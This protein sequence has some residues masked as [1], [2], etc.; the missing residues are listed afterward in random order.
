MSMDDTDNAFLWGFIRR[1][2][3]TETIIQLDQLNH[4]R[5]E[6]SN[7]VWVHLRSDLSRSRKSMQALGL[8]DQVIDVMCADET[9]PKAYAFADGLV[10]YLRGINHNQH[11]DP[12]DMVSLRV[13]L[14]DKLVVTARKRDRGLK[15]AMT[16]KE[17]CQAGEG[18][19][20]AQGLFCS[21]L[22]EM[23]NTVGD[24]VDE[25]DATLS[26]QETEL[27]THNESRQILANVRRQSAAIRRYLAPQKEALDMVYRLQKNF[28]QDSVFEIRE[29]TDR[30]LRYVEDLDLVRER[31]LLLQDEIRNRITEQQGQRLYVI[32]IVSAVFLPLSFL[33]GV[34][35]MNVAGLPGVET[36]SAFIMLSSFMAV[37]AVLVIGIMKWNK[38]I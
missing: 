37:T 4:Q 3:V 10:I 1:S 28:T 30:M 5:V 20:S 18:P 16:L 13:F 17:Q 7:V 21:L 23:A 29:Y 14:S 19:E 34:F 11:A 9:R 38:W 8:A 35:G 24:M 31:A 26:A 32:S 6:D 33:T 12:E 15:S 36:P 25:L 27:A 2:G 22:N